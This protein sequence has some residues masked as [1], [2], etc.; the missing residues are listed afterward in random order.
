MELRN[1]HVVQADGQERNVRAQ[2]VDVRPNGELVFSNGQEL[3]V[4]YGSG[5]WKY[6]EVERQ[7]DR[8]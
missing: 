5:E 8:G 4:M 3:V 2:D 6:V 7:D 1:Y